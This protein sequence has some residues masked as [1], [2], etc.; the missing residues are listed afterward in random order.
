[1][2][3]VAVIDPVGEGV[4]LGI[5]AIT[6]VGD[7]VRDG[8]WVIVEMATTVPVIVVV[9][10]GDR[11]RSVHTRIIQIQNPSRPRTPKIV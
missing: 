4:K 7:A 5:V 8:T 11:L 10:V 2:S 3:I 6:R 1:M 9:G